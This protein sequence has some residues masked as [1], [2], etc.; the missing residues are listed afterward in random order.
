MKLEINSDFRDVYDHWFDL[1]GDIIFIRNAHEESFGMS[2]DQQF[3][4]FKNKGFQVPFYG[5]I[6]DSLLYKYKPRPIVVYTANLHAGEG[7]FLVP[8]SPNTYTVDS[9]ILFKEKY[10]GCVYSELI[11][12]YSTDIEP[13]TYSYKTLF[14]GFKTIGLKYSSNHPWMSN[15]GPSNKVEIISV[16]DR[17]EDEWDFPMYS[18]DYVTNKNNE[19]FYI[20][21]N[22]SP[23]IK[24]T[25]IYELFS[26][27]TEIFLAVKY[28]IK[29]YRK[30]EDFFLINKV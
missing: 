14:I 1:K 29:E 17:T 23:G 19:R 16:R 24:G 20:D 28:Y 18:W 30:K 26:D 25:G 2:K 12:I 8:R 22:I 27:K 4:Y 6:D 10:K 15:C 7:K 21:L 13:V 11:D 9:L 3:E 5:F